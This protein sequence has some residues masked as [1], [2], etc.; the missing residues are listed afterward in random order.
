MKSLAPLIFRFAIAS[1]MLGSLLGCSNENV[2]VHI[3]GVEQDLNI[4]L[5]RID[6]DF[7]LERIYTFRALHF[8]CP[9]PEDAA[10]F[11]TTLIEHGLRDDAH[12]QVRA[13]LRIADYTTA[14]RNTP[15]DLSAPDPPAGLHGT[16]WKGKTCEATIVAHRGTVLV[17]DY[18][19][20]FTK[21]RIDGHFDVVDPVNCTSEDGPPASVDLLWENFSLP[22]SYDEFPECP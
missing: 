17:E 10:K 11:R 5:S 8:A 9:A 13:E 20:D 16:L 14:P 21:G 3:D 19:A 6:V 4:R 7:T 18:E 1:T 12:M 22:N 2:V 15:I